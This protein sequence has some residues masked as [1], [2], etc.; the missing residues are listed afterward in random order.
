MLLIGCEKKQSNDINVK[1]SCEEN[2]S[3]DNVINS[4]NIDTEIIT[5]KEIELGKEITVNKLVTGVKYYGKAR[6]FKDT[7]YL[8]Y[9]CKVDENE[10]PS[11]HVPMKFKYEINDVEYKIIKFNFLGNKI[12]TLK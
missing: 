2:Q 6:V 10:I 9:W 1:F 11:I 3:R 4:S 5:V 7:L 12:K 8:D